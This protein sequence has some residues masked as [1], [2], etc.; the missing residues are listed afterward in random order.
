MPGLQHGHRGLFAFAAAWA[1]RHDAILRDTPATLREATSLRLR[2]VAIRWGVADGVRMTGQFP[3]LEAADA[4]ALPP[5][6]HRVSHPG[7]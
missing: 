7:G 4:G 1:E 2:R 5:P 3:A 6:R